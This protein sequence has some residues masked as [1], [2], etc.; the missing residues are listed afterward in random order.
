[1]K[2]I[3][4]VS[5][6]MT[7]NS[8]LLAQV[9][10]SMQ[11]GPDDPVYTTYAAAT[12]RT[13]YKTDHGY[14]LIFNDPDRAVGFLSSGAGEIGLAFDDMTGPRFRLEE[15]YTAPVINYSYADG[16][17]FTS[18]PYK[19]FR[20]DVVF[21]VYSSTEVILDV[22]VSNEGKFDNLFAIYLFMDLSETVSKDETEITGGFTFSHHIAKDGWM[23]QHSI[24]YEEEYNN[25]FRVYPEADETGIVDAL[26]EIKTPGE[27]DNHGKILYIKKKML[28]PADGSV[29]LRAVRVITSTGTGRSTDASISELQAV[30]PGKLLEKNRNLYVKIPDLQFTDPLHESVYY[31]AFTMIRQCMMP[32]EGSCGQNYYV[33]SR[34]PKWGW[35]YGGQVFHESLAMLAYAYMDPAGAMNSQRIYMERQREDGYINYRTGP[36]LNEDIPYEGEYTSSAPWYNYQNNEI[37]KI[38]GDSNFLKE[39]YRS[40]Q[41]FYNYYTKNRDKDDDGLCEW[42]A[43]AVL[44]SV[45]DARVAVW[46]QVGWPSD[47][48]GPDINSML[49]MEAKSLAEMAKKLGYHD[50]MKKW[51]EDAERR[52]ALINQYMWDDETGFYYNIDR[53]DHDFSYKGNA[54]LRIKEIIGF[55][56]LWSGVASEKQAARLVDHLVNESE[57]W[58]SNGIPTLSADEDYYNPMGYWNGP[59]WVEWNYLIFRGLID[60]GY[61]DAAREL[62]NRLADHLAYHLSRSHNFYEFYSPDDQQA[63]YHSTYI[64]TGLIARFF[65]DLENIVQEN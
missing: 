16:L 31:N 10:W 30:D 46:D 24:P 64:W 7:L 43:H 52:A 51:M 65:I 62:T 8:S 23:T 40:G 2:H 47:F 34:E 44:E 50:E 33:F 17:G 63:G 35:G 54:D 56:P 25:T 60:Y 1:M 12:E 13:E 36:Y 18:Y 28:V 29:H 41:A 22:K 6:L 9:P 58:R 39:A 49:V 48:E 37:F 20:V 38:T 57:F 5:I 14:R 15:Y 45:R 4:L 27:K 26:D 21:L 32:P 42:G 3:L 61:T 19:D 59:V 11:S 55:L 53:N